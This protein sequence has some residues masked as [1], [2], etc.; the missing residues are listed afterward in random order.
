MAYTLWIL[1]PNGNHPVVQRQ[2]L[3]STMLALDVAVRRRQAQGWII[4][5]RN[6]KRVVMTK[7]DQGVAYEIAQEEA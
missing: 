7:G 6:A 5:T 1:T 4:K 3:E 2:E